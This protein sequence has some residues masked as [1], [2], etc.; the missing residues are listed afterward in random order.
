MKGW[1]ICLGGRMRETDTHRWRA[2]NQ[3]VGGRQ[4]REKWM[5]GEDET[6]KDN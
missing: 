3:K 4:T 5:V 1:V 2:D 6:G